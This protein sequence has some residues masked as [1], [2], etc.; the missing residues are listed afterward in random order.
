VLLAYGRRA[1][2]FSWFVKEGR[3]W[4]DFNFAGKHTLLVSE[5]VMPDREAELQLAVAEG[6]AGARARLLVD[7]ST[8]ASAA[9]PQ[10]IPGGIGTLSIQCGHNSPSPVSDE[11]DAP[12]TFSGTLERVV[13]DL[14]PR[15]HPTRQTVEEELAFE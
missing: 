13:V 5:S 3:L 10:L 11:Y 9:L 8:V 6:R 2:G 4:A 12:F 7:G 1:F 15:I 14:G